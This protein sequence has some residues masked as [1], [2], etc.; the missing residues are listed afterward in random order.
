MLRPYGPAVSHDERLERL[1]R[2][3]LRTVAAGLGIDG[4]VAAPNDRHV[5]AGLVQPIE[6]LLSPI[7]QRF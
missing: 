2:S 5:F 1:L 3:G 4:R 7:T 6:R